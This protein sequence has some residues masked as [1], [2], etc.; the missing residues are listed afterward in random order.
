MCATNLVSFFLTL[1]RLAASIFYSLDE[2]DVL[3]EMSKP[4]R[5]KKDATSNFM[6]D[7]KTRKASLVRLKKEAKD[8]S[9]TMTRMF[10]SLFRAGRPEGCFCGECQL[11][12]VEI[13]R[14][15]FHSF[16]HSSGESESMRLSGMSQHFLSGFAEIPVE[17]Q[18][19]SSPEP[20]AGPSSEPQ[21]GVSWE[22]QAGPSSEP[23][24]GVSWEPQ[25]GPS[26]EPQTGKYQ[27]MNIYISLPLCLLL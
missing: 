1:Q 25:A 22:P 12:M 27:L 24:T 19:S 11:P 18:F 4:G 8:E 13:P 20:Q 14:S 26:S 7:P 6:I 2:I 17:T 16:D 21:T 15:E 3:E 10:N 23:Q 5:R 9:R